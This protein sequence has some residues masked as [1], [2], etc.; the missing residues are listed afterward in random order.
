MRHLCSAS[1]IGADFFIEGQGLS[2]ISCDETTEWGKMEDEGYLFDGW[3]PDKPTFRGRSDGMFAPPP[4]LGCLLVSREK[5]TLA[6]TR[7]G[8]ILKFRT[9]LAVLF[10]IAAR[11]KGRAFHRAA[12]SPFK[13]FIQ[14]DHVSHPDPKW[15]RNDC[16]PLIPFYIMD[17]A[18]D[19]TASKEARTWFETL[20]RCDISH[21]ERITKGAHFLNLAMNANGLEEFINYFIVLDAIFGHRGAVEASIHAGISSLADASRFTDKVSWLFDLRSDLVHGGAR[22]IEEW[23]KFGRYKKHFRSHPLDDVKQLSEMS[24]LSAPGLFVSPRLPQN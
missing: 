7:F 5:G 8:A 3:R 1:V 14:V 6:G 16:E 11:R 10:S 2:V 13:F 24:V 15:T 21:R 18:F 12:A 23:P 4:N 20:E 17:I 19:S 22:Y 9:L